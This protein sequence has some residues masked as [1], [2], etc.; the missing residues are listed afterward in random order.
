MEGREGVLVSWI[1]FNHDP[2]ERVVI[3]QACDPVAMEHHAAGK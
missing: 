2:F 1:A 3:L